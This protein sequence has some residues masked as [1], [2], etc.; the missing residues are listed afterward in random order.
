VYV[1]ASTTFNLLNPTHPTGT[2]V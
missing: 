2:V 1:D